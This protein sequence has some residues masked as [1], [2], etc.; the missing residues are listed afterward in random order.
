MR[1]KPL[2]LLM[3]R[4]GKGKNSATPPS[5]EFGKYKEGP[6][7]EGFYKIPMGCY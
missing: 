2:I 7:F 1:I 5:H 6:I 4:N 3:I